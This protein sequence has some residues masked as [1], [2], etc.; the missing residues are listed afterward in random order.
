MNIL[1][2]ERN[3]DILRRLRF[4]L[5]SAVQLKKRYMILSK[6]INRYYLIFEN[7]DLIV[8][9]SFVIRQKRLIYLTF[10]KFKIHA[11][12]IERNLIMNF[13]MKGKKIISLTF[14]LLEELFD[15][16]K[17]HSYSGIN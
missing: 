8:N 9:I 17:I 14:S 12:E 1:P 3:I 10:L 15:L 4:D 7:T 16:I 5:L 13:D 2:I 11:L 6:L